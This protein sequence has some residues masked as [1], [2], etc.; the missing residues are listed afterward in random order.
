LNGYSHALAPL[1]TRIEDMSLLCASLLPRVAPNG[2]EGV[3]FTPAAARA[4]LAHRWPLNV[5]ELQQWLARAAVLSRG[6]RIGA[7]PLAP[8]PSASSLRISRPIL[9]KRRARAAQ[10]R[11]RTKSGGTKSCDVI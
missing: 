6:R 5:R 3:A 9:P 11:S 10:A 4:M 1:R 7:A 8:A 2:A